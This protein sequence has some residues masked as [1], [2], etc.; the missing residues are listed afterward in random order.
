M[1]D[2]DIMTTRKD[3]NNYQPTKIIYDQ[4]SMSMVNKII[5]KSNSHHIKP[6]RNNLTYTSFETIWDQSSLRQVDKKSKEVVSSKI[7]FYF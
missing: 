4:N 2:V 1:N 5:A 7:R 6:E 3:N